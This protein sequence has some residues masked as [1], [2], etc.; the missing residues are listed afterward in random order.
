VIFSLLVLL[1]GTVAPE[2]ASTSSKEPKAYSPAPAELGKREERLLGAHNRERALVGAPPLRWDTALAASAAAY[3]PTL[4]SFGRLVHSPRAS[5]PAQGENLWFGTKGAYTLEQMV[6]S[7]IEEKR[8]FRSGSFPNV[9]ST[10]AWLDV[11]HYTQ[12][13]WRST[14]SLGCAIHSTRDR[15][16]LICRYSPRG[17][18]DGQVVP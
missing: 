11:S 18:R 8:H 4:G 12:L 5:R 2:T 1:F 6:G 13:I 9:S 17:N 14:T 7:W 10:G 15:D 3:G 16:F